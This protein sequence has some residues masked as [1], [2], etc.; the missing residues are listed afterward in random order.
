MNEHRR[1]PQVAGGWTSMDN[2]NSIW[3][4]QSLG[5]DFDRFHEDPGA[6]RA[7]GQGAG[8]F[9][10][11]AGRDDDLPDMSHRMAPYQAGRT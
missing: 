2:A 1:K 10:I 8:V 7:F 4:R 5:A 3:K 6:R 9:F 11:R